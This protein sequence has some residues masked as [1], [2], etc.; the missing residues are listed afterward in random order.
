MS[1]FSSST[2]YIFTN[3]IANSKN[4]VSSNNIDIS[5][6]TKI[7]NDNY[8]VGNDHTN[9]PALMLLKDPLSYYQGLKSHSN[10]N[11]NSNSN[12]YC[13]H[14]N[15]LFFNTSNNSNGNNFYNA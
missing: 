3:T 12:S 4:V 1:L 11:S 14:H 2:N 8:N 6:N 5:N 13:S 10:S 7:I 9:C 15:G